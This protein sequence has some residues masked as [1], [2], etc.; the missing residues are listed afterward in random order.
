MTKNIGH[1]LVVAGLFLMVFAGLVLFDALA[2]LAWAEA[3]FGL[4]FATSGWHLR[5][6]GLSDVS[7]GW[8]WRRFLLVVAPS[9][10]VLYVAGYFILMDRSRPTDPICER[11]FQSSLRG[12]HYSRGWGHWR[13]YPDVTIFNIMFQP[14]DTFYFKWFPRSD[15]DIERLRALGYYQ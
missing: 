13:P 6:R 14:A 10:P 11:R 15:D 2:S 4:L 7:R 8:T 9:L 3:V 1:P 12:V 5:R